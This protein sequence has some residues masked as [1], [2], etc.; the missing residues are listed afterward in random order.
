MLKRVGEA[1]YFLFV[2]LRESGISRVYV[3]IF[4]VY[5]TAAIVSISRFMRDLCA[6]LLQP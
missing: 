1:E 5:S 4:R 3:R 6:K 2:R